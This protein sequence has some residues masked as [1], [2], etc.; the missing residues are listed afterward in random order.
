MNKIKGILLDGIKSEV[1]EI[2]HT[3][4]NL[5][6]LICC[7]CIDITSRTI[8]GRRYYF[9]CDDLGWYKE[10]INPTGVYLGPCPDIAFVGKIF[11]VS[12]NGVDDI[13]SL[14]DDDIAYLNYH[15]K[16]GTIFLPV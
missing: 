10:I 13:C 5:R 8:R 4:E 16:Y 2:E 3:V 7:S 14:S 15:I 9:V 6:E 11:I 12:F 1:V